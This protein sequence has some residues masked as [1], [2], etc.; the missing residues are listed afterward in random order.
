MIS[1]DVGSRCAALLVSCVLKVSVTKNL[2][3]DAKNVCKLLVQVSGARFW[4]MC[5]P[6]FCYIHI[7]Q[8]W[9]SLKEL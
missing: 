8:L 7:L 9:H 2:Q 6:F 1:A 3:K 5:Y 4:S